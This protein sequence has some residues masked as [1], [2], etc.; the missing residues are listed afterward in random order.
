MAQAT[1]DNERAF[2]DAVVALLHD[3][4]GWASRIEGMP[5]DILDHP[6]EEDLIA[7]WAKILFINNCG[8]NRLNGVPL[9]D[10]E[11]ERLL[12]KVR[13]ANAPLAANAFINGGT[14]SVLR[15]HNS[16]DEAHRD[17]EVAL[18]IY[19]QNEIA[20]GSSF[21]QIARQP[22]FKMSPET[23]KSRRGDV[24]LLINGMPVI[25]VE[26]KKSGIPVEQACNQ[27]GKYVFEH[28]FTGFFGLVQIF[29]AMTP[30]ETRY[31]AN[32]G[33]G[34]ICE[35]RNMFHW[36]DFRNLPVNA[37]YDVVEELLSIPMAHQ[38][39]GF[40]SVADE[41]DGVLKIMRS[42]QY[43]AVREI[44]NAL[45]KIL[46]GEPSQTGGHIWHTTGS[47]KTLTSF[48]AAQLIA[49]KKMVDKVVFLTDRIELGTQSFLAY[50][51]FAGGSA[52][53]VF[54]TDNTGELKSLLGSSYQDGGLIVTSIQKMDK[55]CKA[56]AGYLLPSER[57][58]YQRLRIV[59]IVDECHRS[60]F[61]SMMHTIKQTFKQSTF[62]GFTGTPILED[63]MKA[64]S[65]TVM[66]FGNELHR[67]DLAD[68]IRDGN[69]LGFDTTMVRVW[70]DSDLKKCVA[71]REVEAFSPEAALADPKKAERYLE[72]CNNWSMKRV[73]AALPSGQY[74]DERYQKA[75]VGDI[76]D[77]FDMLT[78]QR[79]FHAI[80][81]T[82]SIQEAVDYYHHFKA[83]GTDLKVTTLFDPNIDAND[84]RVIDRAKALLEIVT[85]YNRMFGTVY[86]P[87]TF[88]QMKKEIA[89]RLAHRNGLGG[90]PAEQLNL[91]IVV[92]QMLTGFDSK[93]VNTL[94]LDKELKNEGLIQAFSR[95][96][97]I[98]GNQK[99]AGLIRY[100]RQPYT[101]HDNIAEAVKLYSGEQA[102]G[103]FVDRLAIN[104]RS[105]NDTVERIRQ[106]N[107]PED[108]SRLP[109]AEEDRRAFAESFAQ[110]T[111]RILAA[112][113]QGFNW[114]QQDYVCKE[115]KSL[116]LPLSAPSQAPGVLLASDPTAEEQRPQENAGVGIL[117]DDPTEEAPR[118]VMNEVIHVAITQEQYN[119]M[120]QRYAELP[121]TRTAGKDFAYDID[122]YLSS[123]QDAS[124]N[125]E[126]M[127][128]RFTKFLKALQKGEAVDEIEKALHTTFALLPRDEQDLA[129]RICTD[130]KSGNL[131]IKKGKTFQD[132]L[133]EYKI[134]HRNDKI[135]L[136]AQMLGLNEELLREIMN[137]KL[138][139]ATLTQNGR[140]EKLVSSVD[141]KC[142]KQ[143]FEAQ[144]L[145][146]IS[147][148]ELHVKVYAKLEAFILTF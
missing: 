99:Q 41:S 42:Y 15:D 4:A 94:F 136:F 125:N 143:T 79:L 133:T 114:E 27:I 82:S 6:T 14:V 75:V 131:T 140:F 26:M 126:Y 62:F 59:F 54:E 87:A 108:F 83:S 118:K 65:T 31:F 104:L 141:W 17:L 46:D 25:H 103:L 51:N 137:M 33:P 68:G 61:G 38:L 105:I 49:Q 144:G 100:Y 18:K 129:E 106:C 122:P 44:V 64:D 78:S 97:R 12:L 135:H 81:A 128:S 45:Q 139:R 57:E 113:Q 36:G 32:P 80:F 23:Q 66:I 111:R 50:K 35:R 148:I 30:E 112:Q 37:W 63:N 89:G 101:M 24:M 134:G 73:E 71:L 76:L 58:A 109:K 127:Q 123:T 13:L 39:I 69:V 2:E 86:S 98:Y 85:D 115:D 29:V 21:Y 11:M 74:R 47:G 22:Q 5:S 48:K 53:E 92:D 8:P 7:N 16:P 120:K 117:D 138:T 77:N 132:Y 84:E 56:E 52:Q 121:K 20:A 147:E 146:Q 72:I 91:L 124:I 9:S 60:T 96:N 3:T 40:Y 70:K 55:L 145:G 93:W 88:Q 28:V 1:F 19:D 10:S 107:M 95:T 142:A 43:Y 116:S 90:K 34:A 130:M 119:A 110:L 67:Y 102:L